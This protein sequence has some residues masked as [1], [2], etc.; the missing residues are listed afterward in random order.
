MN[1]S[2][3][4]ERSIGQDEIVT[5]P[6]SDTLCATLTASAQDS[7][8]CNGTLEFWGEQGSDAWRVHLSNA[9]ALTADCYVAIVR[10]DDGDDAELGRFARQSE[11]VG[12]AT[13]Y[14]VDRGALGR[15]CADWLAIEYIDAKGVS[16]IAIESVEVA[17]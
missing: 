11:A 10:S 17:S 13:E 4:I 7:A 16:R 1:A 3:L 5:A 9:P 6:Y 15:G 14:M 12:A 2:T 8:D